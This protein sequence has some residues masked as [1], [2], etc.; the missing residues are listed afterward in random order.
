MKRTWAIIGADD[1]PASFQW[2]QSFFGQ[3]ETQPAYSYFG[4]TQDHGG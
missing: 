3:P 2:Y 4:Q 1:V